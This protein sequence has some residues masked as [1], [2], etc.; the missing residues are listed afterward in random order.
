MS[1]FNN[2]HKLTEKKAKKNLNQ[3]ALEKASSK[4]SK[5]MHTTMLH[6][7]CLYIGLD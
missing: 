2:H 1:T 3:N 7:D 5:K 6:K 4:S